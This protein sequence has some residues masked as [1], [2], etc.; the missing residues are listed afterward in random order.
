M[1]SI[2]VEELH[3][4]L[5]HLQEKNSTL[6]DTRSSEMY[7]DEHIDGARNIP[8]AQLED[9][10]EELKNFENI[11]LQ[12]NCGGGSAK[13]CAKLEGLGLSNAVNVEGGIT[14]WK[15][16]GFDVVSQ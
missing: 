14:A 15:E 3:S 10:L 13:A 9:H 5:P 4:L 8:S 6:I 16:A 1:N 7:G 11:Y 2:T 12:C